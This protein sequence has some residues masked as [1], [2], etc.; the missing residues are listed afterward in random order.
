[1]KLTKYINNLKTFNVFTKYNQISKDI[2]ADITRR[3]EAEGLSLSDTPDVVICVG[4]DG[5][6]L[7][8][9]AKY[10]DQI[11]EILFCGVHTGS[12]G[13][14]T[15]FEHERVPELVEL[16]TTSKYYYVENSRM[17][18]SRIY[19]IKG[20]TRFLALNEG[21]VENNVRTQVMD[22]YI[23]KNYFES[24]R[25]NGLNF[26]T[27]TGSTGY[28][29]SLGGAVLHPQIDGFQMCEVAPINNREYRPLGSSFV[30]SHKHVVTIKMKETYGLV[31]GYDSQ[32]IELD[33]EYPGVEKIEFGIA[34]ES[35]RFL[36]FSHKPFSQRVKNNFI[37]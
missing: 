36:R 20:V 24:F 5:T 3:L 15:D 26:S 19:H 28:N 12:L 21:R 4:G 11:D 34:K 25:G 27:P 13:F 2:A 8:A 32:T 18:E 16:I 9:I 31:F 17:L 29:K 30:L 35:T 22:V 14:L 7:R 6:C 37:K 33:E 1:M 23:D 10:I